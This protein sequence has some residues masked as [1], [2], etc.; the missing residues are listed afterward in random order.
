MQKGPEGPLDVRANAGMPAGCGGTTIL[1]SIVVFQ[2]YE[3]VVCI[4]E[5][6]EQPTTRGVATAFARRYTLSPR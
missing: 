3:V 4:S 6:C 5:P 1:Q 2:G